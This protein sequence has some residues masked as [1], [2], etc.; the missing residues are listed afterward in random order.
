M[1]RLLYR[2]S[3]TAPGAGCGVALAAGPTPVRAL[4]RTG[5]GGWIRTN[6]LRVMSPTSCHCSTARIEYSKTPGALRGAIVRALSPG[7]AT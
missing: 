6:D 7:M 5:C 4:W 3:Y 1:S 2:L